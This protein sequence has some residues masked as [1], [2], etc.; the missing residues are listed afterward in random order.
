MLFVISRHSKA[1]LMRSLFA[2]LATRG[3]CFRYGH[4][5]IQIIAVTLDLVL[6]L[7]FVCA[8]RQQRRRRKGAEW[9]SWSCYRLPPLGGAQRAGDGGSP[10]SPQPDGD[11]GKWGGRT[12]YGP[13]RSSRKHVGSATKLWFFKVCYNKAHIKKSGKNKGKMLGNAWSWWKGSSLRLLPDRGVYNECM[14]EGG[15]EEKERET[16]R[17]ERERSASAL[18][19]IH[20]TFSSLTVQPRNLPRAWPRKGPKP[21][22]KE[23]DGFCGTSSSNSFTTFLVF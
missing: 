14:G 15:G 18:V 20:S 2:P 5:N 22:Q 8:P 19:W 11:A 13:V 23:P 4:Q 17:E 16:E 7:S 1:A 9:G 12:G 3:S 6:S 21:D 10:P